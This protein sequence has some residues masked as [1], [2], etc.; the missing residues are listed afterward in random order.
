MKIY[1]FQDDQVFCFPSGGFLI[2]KNKAK[3]K[4]NFE[5]GF[6]VTFKVKNM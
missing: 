2:A 1:K 4:R 6:A 3:Q 5:I